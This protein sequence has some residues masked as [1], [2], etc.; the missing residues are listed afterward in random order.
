MGKQRVRVGD[1]FQIP[2]SD[3]RMAYGQYVFR[4]KR[5][6]PIIRV[7]DFITEDE[8]EFNEIRERLA[9][10]KLLFPPVITG[11]FA[12]VRTGLWK[13]I[14]RMPVDDFEYPN[15]VSVFH[16]GYKPLGYWFLI[17]KENDIRI[18]RHLPEKYKNLEFLAVWSPYDIVHRIE[19][20]ENPYAEMIRRG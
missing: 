5:N 10:A 20:G 12:A 14:G 6:G 1:V 2:L 4:D 15:F 19:T 8:M 17:T 9:N 3:G 16:E 13:V 7:F 18:G 11:V